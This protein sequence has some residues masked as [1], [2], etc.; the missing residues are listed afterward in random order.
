MVK[1]KIVKVAPDLSLGHES[2]LEGMRHRHK[3]WLGDIEIKDTDCLECDMCRC[4][5][6]S[7]SSESRS[8]IEAQLKKWH[9]RKTVTEQPPARSPLTSMQHQRRTIS[10]VVSI[11]AGGQ[12]R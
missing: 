4:T 8:G 1:K 12:R 10:H 7:F 2:D 11:M 6:V 9:G 3:G 5:L